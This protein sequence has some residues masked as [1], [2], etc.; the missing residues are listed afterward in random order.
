MNAKC[1]PALLFAVGLA[2]ASTTA[3]G[4][5]GQAIDV[6]APACSSDGS[7]VVFASNTFNNGGNSDLWQLTLAG[8]QL[9]QVTCTSSIEENDPACSADGAKI[10]YSRSASD[11]ESVWIMDIN[12]SNPRRVSRENRT[13][14]TPSWMS[15]SERLVCDADGD[16]LLTNLSQEEIRFLVASSDYLGSP[17]CS[18]NDSL[19]VYERRPNSCAICQPEGKVCSQI[20]KRSIIV[21][22]APVQL[23]TG[24][25][26]DS[27]PRISP[28]NARIAFESN[29]DQAN[30][31][32]SSVYTMNVDGTGLTRVVIQGNAYDPSW[33]PDGR[34]VFVLG[35]IDANAGDETLNI[36]LI[37]QDGTGLTRV[38]QTV[39]APSMAPKGGTFSSF[40]QTVTL[41]CSTSGATIRYTTDGS[42]P[43]E[44][45]PVYS[46]PIS[47]SGPGMVRAKAWKAGFFPSPITRG[48]FEQNP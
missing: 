19:L 15:D 20:W 6:S 13:A 21:M 29:R 24:H 38:T 16:L 14:S 28:D 2:V 32:N 41:A 25:Y 18:G 34:I 47:V 36:A 44:S 46:S 10:A 3:F 26:E 11:D 37:N 8:N 42:A 27:R 43:T 48:E 30:G 7:L 31:H 33:V 17:H 22:T 9:T 5:E 40:P 23:T 45:S 35:E 1:I 39:A 12:G 4:D